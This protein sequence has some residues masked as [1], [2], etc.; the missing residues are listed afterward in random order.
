MIPEEVLC[1]LCNAPSFA[2]TGKPER[3]TVFAFQCPRCRHIWER[4]FGLE[5]AAANDP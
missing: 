2:I 5:E 3:G 4:D 1:P